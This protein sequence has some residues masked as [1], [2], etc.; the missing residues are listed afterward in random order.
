[1]TSD[2]QIADKE[3]L[4]DMINTLKYTLSIVMTDAYCL[5]IMASMEE[6]SIEYNLQLINEIESLKKEVFELVLCSFNNFIKDKNLISARASKEI[7]IR[8][9]IIE[10]MEQNIKKTN[11]ISVGS[12]LLLP[13][14]SL[15]IIPLGALK[16]ELDKFRKN[17]SE[18]IMEITESIKNDYETAH[19]AFYQLTDS[20]RTDYLQS[21]RKL[22]ELRQK[23]LE[24]QE[25]IDDLIQ[26][27]NPESI[28]LPLFDILTPEV[29]ESTKQYIK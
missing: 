5:L 12:L 15:F 21:K 4:E 23:A 1:M 8:K 11:I 26:L 18:E 6:R 28:N 9:D 19:I 27:V 2:L 13:M 17:E 3:T 22:E 29:E 7:S 20:L 16:I 14:L 25:I 24:G 10:Q